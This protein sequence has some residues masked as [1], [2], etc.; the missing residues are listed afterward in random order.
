MLQ[1][2]ITIFFLTSLKILIL[3]F[4]REIEKKLYVQTL[5]PGLNVLWKNCGNEI[6]F[7]NEGWH[8]FDVK[9]PPMRGRDYELGE[10]VKLVTVEGGGRRSREVTFKA[11]E[12]DY[13]EEKS[14]KENE[15]RT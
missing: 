8:L 2:V 15:K 5:Y 11:E 9:N 14:S 6:S 4:C 12:F 1:T 3:H 13:E 10:K 7:C